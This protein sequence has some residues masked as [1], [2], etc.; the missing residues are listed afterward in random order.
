MAQQSL[1]EK[2]RVGAAQMGRGPTS[3]RSRL[4]AEQLLMEVTILSL[5]QSVIMSFQLD[6]LSVKISLSLLLSFQVDLCLSP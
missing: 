6:F 4:D 5:L 3:K 2:K 1:V